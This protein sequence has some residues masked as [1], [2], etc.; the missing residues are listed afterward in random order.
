MNL[1][2]LCS[3]RCLWRKPCNSR[4]CFW[5][6]ESGTGNT[7]NSALTREINEETESKIH[8]LAENRD[9]FDIHFCVG[10]KPCKM[11]P[12]ISSW[13]TQW[14]RHSGTNIHGTNSDICTSRKDNELANGWGSR[15]FMRVTKYCIKARVL[16][17]TP[18]LTWSSLTEKTQRWMGCCIIA[19]Q[20]A[21][22]IAIAAPPPP[23]QFSVPDFEKKTIRSGGGGASLNLLNFFLSVRWVISWSKVLQHVIV[24]Q[25][26]KTFPDFK[27]AKR[28]LPRSQKPTSAIQILTLWNPVH[29]HH[30]YLRKYIQY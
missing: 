7:Q 23:P 26:V 13:G 3:K 15:S 12:L 5:L 8:F 29:T 14:F 2:L 11:S 30:V 22:W 17:C 6:R 25:L 21:L 9:G 24:A 10:S 18:P 16:G 1:A 27:K 20:P 19:K 4:T 28:S